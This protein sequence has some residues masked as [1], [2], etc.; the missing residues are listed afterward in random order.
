MQQSQSGQLNPEA[1]EEAP[2]YVKY[3]VKALATTGGGLALLLGAINALTSIVTLSPVAIVMSIWLMVLGFA[4]VVVESPCCCVFVEHVNKITAMVDSKPLIFKAGVY[5][6]GPIPAIIFAFSF[7]ILFGSALII[8]AGV[9]YGFMALGK[10][11]DRR[12]MARNAQTVVPTYPNPSQSQLDKVTVVKTAP[13]RPQAPW[14]REAPP[15][16][17]TDLQSNSVTGRIG[18]DTSY[19]QSSTTD[20]SS[21]DPYRNSTPNPASSDKP[22]PNQPYNP[23]Q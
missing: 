19:L 21:N 14:E 5:V 12:E 22:I 3:G 8:A 6:F 16:A 2:W 10:K 23:F 4:V 1:Q 15:P 17:Y 11:A 13:L 7:T 9:I 18:W 20:V